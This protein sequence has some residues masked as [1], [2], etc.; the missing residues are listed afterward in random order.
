MARPS[1]S[2][3]VGH[4]TTD[5][6]RSRSWTM[7]VTRASC[8]ASFSPKYAVHGP[9][10]LKS[11]VTT[12]KTPPKCP[13]RDAPSSR[14]PRGPASTV[15][16]GRPP[17]CDGDLRRDHRHVDIDPVELGGGRFQG[18]EVPLDRAHLPPHRRSGQ[19][20]SGPL[21]KRVLQ[22]GPGQRREPG[23][24]LCQPGSAEE[25]LG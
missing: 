6:G 9:A 20:F 11:F 2:R 16:P 13:G 10:R 21:D 3:T 24:G 22:N 4:P 1:G 12:V 8:W 19:R 14:V 17:G 25:L 15:T 7:R 23:D 18:F 5:T